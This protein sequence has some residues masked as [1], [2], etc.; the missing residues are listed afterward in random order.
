MSKAANKK[1]LDD[2]CEQLKEVPHR[3]GKAVA[4]QVYQEVI[5]ATAMDSGQAALNWHIEGY[6]GGYQM[7]SQKMWWGWKTKDT[8]NPPTPPAGYKGTKGD[9]ASAV[10]EYQFRQMAE[11]IAVLP[12]EFDGIVVYNP[13][14]PGFAG[15]EPGSDANYRQASIGSVPVEGIVNDALAKVYG[16]V[17]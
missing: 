15:F 17:S 5:L 4:I 10:V 16:A 1:Y 7:T 11:A 9:N 14:E 6:V 3:L 2:L 13:I 12:A 8:D